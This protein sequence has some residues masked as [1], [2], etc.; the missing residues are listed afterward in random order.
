[1]ADEAALEEG[2]WADAL[3]A[4]DDLV[5]DHEVHGLNLL[6]QRADGGEGNHASH[7]DVS[8]GGDVGASGD[9]MRRKLVVRTMA[10][11]EGDG[12]AGVLEDEDGG[13]RLAP[14]GVGVHLGDRGVAI[15]LVEAGTANDGDM[16]GT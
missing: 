4:V 2:E 9:L 1:M 8:E 16:D 14:G 7:A 13:R 6:L 15:D 12:D 5:G 11:Q 10:G 3:G